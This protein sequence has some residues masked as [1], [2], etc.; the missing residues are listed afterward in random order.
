[1]T[2]KIIAVLLSVL[3]LAALTAP[4]FAADE[5]ADILL[6][7]STLDTKAQVNGQT[8]YLPVRAV[9]QAL[10][11]A[12]TWSDQNGIQ[13][14]TIMKNGDTVA[15]SLTR[16]EINDNGHAF[17]AGVYAGKGLVII[18]GRMYADSGL[19]SSI[20]PVRSAYDTK[21]NLVTIRRY[22][23]NSITVVTERLTSDKEHLRAA[24]QYPQLSGLA[25]AEAQNAV[26]TLLKQSAQKALNEGEKNASEMAQ[27]IRDG[28]TGAVGMCETF[29]DYMVQYNQNSLV[30]VVLTNYQ[31]AGGAHGS[32]VQSSFTIDLL[33][34]K[35][36]SLEDLMDSSADY[37]KFLNESIRREI[38]RRAD[39]G[40]LCE[41]EFSRFK[42]IGANPEYY[43]SGSAL[44]LYFQ[45]YAYF[46][47]A[48]G[49][50]E[51]GVKFTGMRDMLKREVSF[52]YDIGE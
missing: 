26:N 11:Y 10:G 44:V 15:L 18:K 37:A 42:D 52:L 20:F 45:E 29:F 40:E 41:F 31:Y 7:K 51:F 16:Q 28:Y 48:A 5:G 17:A 9:C 24:L 49:I 35:A 2:K 43:L 12:V 47:Y 30:S 25:N 38:D 22:R 8:V 33:S 23:E 13:A 36:L 32:T 19:F 21:E 14:A 27:A 3:V 46:P 34:G 50:Q 6:G 4:A 39:A 1:M